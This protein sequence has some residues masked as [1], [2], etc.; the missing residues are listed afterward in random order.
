MYA[1]LRDSDVRFISVRSAL[2]SRRSGS[3]RSRVGYRRSQS[4]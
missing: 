4:G 1:A 3:M 2:D